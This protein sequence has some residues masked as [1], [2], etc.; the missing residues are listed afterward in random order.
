MYKTYDQPIK[1]YPQP[2]EIKDIK[3]LLEE[4]DIII[5]DVKVP[6]FSFEPAG[7][8]NSEK[9]PPNRLFEIIYSL[10]DVSNLF[11][12]TSTIMNKLDKELNFKGKA[13]E[14][15]MCHIWCFYIIF[16]FIK[17]EIT[18]F[19]G[20]DE[21]N[22]FFLEF[23]SNKKPIENFFKDKQTLLLLLNKNNDIKAINEKLIGN[24]KLL[25]EETQK[26]D[27][28]EKLLEVFDQLEKIYIPW[29]KYKNRLFNQSQIQYLKIGQF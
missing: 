9:I 2:P 6:C 26:T 8:H 3:S 27:S 14:F 12:N 24:Q 15:L 23:L 19:Y 22:P 20:N 17:S 7:K 16:G 4:R 5:E 21:E 28:F 11:E 18:V 29:N 13:F 25:Y 10:L 1:Y